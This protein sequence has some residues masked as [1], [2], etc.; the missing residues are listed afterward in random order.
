ME[1]DAFSHIWRSCDLQILHRCPPLSRKR[2]FDIS[3]LIK[4]ILPQIQN[5]NTHFF[6]TFWNGHNILCLH[7]STKLLLS[8]IIWPYHSSNYSFLTIFVLISV[9]SHNSEPATVP[10]YLPTFHN[11]QNYPAPPLLSILSSHYCLSR[12]VKIGVHPSNYAF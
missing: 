1:L 12:S 3:N 6:L 10:I 11:V 5:C 2:P 8:D 4:R 7:R 9:I